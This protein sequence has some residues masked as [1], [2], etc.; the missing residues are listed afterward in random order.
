MI[1]KKIENL[2]P[3]LEEGDRARL[4]NLSE[5]INKV[6]EIITEVNLFLQQEN[7]KRILI[8]ITGCT[9]NDASKLVK[10]IRQYH[11]SQGDNTVYEFIF[12]NPDTELRVVDGDNQE[13]VK[14]D[15][16]AAYT[17]CKVVDG[18]SEVFSNSPCDNCNNNPKNGG[19]GICNCTLSNPNITC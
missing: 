9:H 11:E 17:Y 5:V 19:S 12:T 15:P 10:A 16:D 7:K 4:P 13:I 18:H 14:V 8:Q 6:N 1:Y 3:V 2:L